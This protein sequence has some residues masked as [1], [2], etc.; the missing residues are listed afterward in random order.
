MRATLSVDKQ[1]GAPVASKHKFAHGKVGQSEVDSHTF[2]VSSDLD[3]LTLYLS[4]GNGWDRWPTNDLDLI[5]RDPNGTRHFAGVTLSG[6]ERVIRNNPMPGVWTALVE[7]FTVWP[8][9]DGDVTEPYQLR[10][11]VDLR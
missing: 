7:G 5:L 8:N 1:K 3:E 10:S 2:E 4:W 11:D 6:P 9:E